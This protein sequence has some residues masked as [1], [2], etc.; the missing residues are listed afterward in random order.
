MKYRIK[1]KS[2]LKIKL[3]YLRLRAVARSERTSQATNEI[4]NLIEF[5]PGPL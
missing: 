3:T 4:Q 1:L 5:S 2:K